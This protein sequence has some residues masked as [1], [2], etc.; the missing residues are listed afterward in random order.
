M[1]AARRARRRARAPRSRPARRRSRSSPRRDGAARAR[2]APPRRARRC[3]RSLPLY[4][5][6]G[7]RLGA[8]V[9]GVQRRAA[10]AADL[11]GAYSVVGEGGYDVGSVLRFWLWHVEELDALRGDRPGGG[12]RSCSS[13]GRAAARARCRST[14]PRPSRSSSPGRSSVGAFASRFAS[15]R[16]QDRYLFFLAPLLVVVLLGVGR[17][18]RAAAAGPRS[19]SAAL[20]ALALPLAF[21]YARF[22]GEPAKSDTLGPA[23]ALDGQRAPRRRLVLGHG[24]VVG[25]ALVA[26]FV[27]RARRVRGRRAARPARALRRRLAARLVGAAR[28]SSGGRGRAL[29]GHPRC[30]R[31]T[32]S[33]RRAGGR[34]GRRRSGPAA[35][36]VSPST[37]TSSSTGASGRSTTRR[38]RRR[39]GSARRRVHRSIRARR[40][41]SRDSRR[42]SRATRRTRCSTA[43]S[44]RTARSWRATSARDDALAPDRAAVVATTS[45]RASTRTTSG[46]ARG[47]WRRLRCA[48]GTLTGARALRP[49]PL[50]RAADARARDASARPTASRGSPSRRT[51]TR[52]CAFRSSPR[53]RTCAVRF[54]V[55]PTAVPAEVI[56]G[57]DRRPRARR[58]LRRLRP[59]RARRMRIVVDVSPL[60]HPRTG[61]GN[62]IRG[63]L[64]GMAAAAGGRHELVAFAPTSLRGP[65][66]IRAA[67]DGI[68]RRAAARGGCPPH[69]RCGRPGAASGGHPSSARRAARRV[70]LQ[71]LDVPAA[72]GGVRATV[73]HDLV[74]LHHPSGAR[75]GPCRCTRARPATRRATCDVVFANSQFTAADLV[76]LARDRGGADRRS[77]RP[78]LAHGL[79]PDG[80]AAD[81]GGAVRCSALGTIEPRKNLARLVE[82]WR[83]LDGELGLVARGRGGLG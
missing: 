55:S 73:F 37:R 10:V 24:R 77:R 81:L 83:L 53:E 36:T 79:G 72:A 60:S 50:R 64:A 45:R 63:S 28:R 8:L 49:D 57:S 18:R 6:L 35:R 2:A 1:G 7:R 67:L 54:T 65:D 41:S 40:A 42:R 16:V 31:A 15:D 23:P 3:A 74:P 33:T 26:L 39:A 69:T 44:R 43:R 75:R 12:A 47:H 9:V 56:P 34:G 71:R 32:G 30:R 59:R 51:G 76:E 21:P 17:S 38:R 13:L 20:V 22:I 11:L 19:R 61:I 48:G 66:A 5:L 52:R 80:D 62:Y 68:R 70:P 25:A 46:R 82:A 78:G 14:S 29:P 58:P 27:A 4:V